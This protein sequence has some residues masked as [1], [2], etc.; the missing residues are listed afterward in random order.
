M[1]KS[2]PKKIFSKGAQLCFK[3][4]SLSIIHQISKKNFYLYVTVY[5]V[6]VR[7]WS[8]ENADEKARIL[9]HRESKTSK[10][11]NRQETDTVPLRCKFFLSDLGRETA[12]K[13]IFNELSPSPAPG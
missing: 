7:I 10:N 6:R 12:R 9:F 13:N 11:K 3:Y 5:L 2:F 4:R 8:Y 1:D